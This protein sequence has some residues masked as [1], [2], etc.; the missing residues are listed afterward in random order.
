MHNLLNCTCSDKFSSLAPFLLRVVVGA[1][2]LA[3]GWQKL[4]GGVDGTAGF[5]GTLGFPAPELFAVLLIAAEVLGGAFLILG[6]FT[7]WAAKVLI[8]VSA[9]ALVSVHL[10]K[11]FFVAN[12]GYEFILLILVTVISVMITGPGRWSLDS[13]LRKH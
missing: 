12:G 4:S 10:T 8:I 5:L 9:V 2:F 3:H 13:K 11:G 7:H 6:L 1:I